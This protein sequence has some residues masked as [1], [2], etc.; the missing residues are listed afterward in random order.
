MTLASNEAGPKPRRADT[1]PSGAIRFSICTLVTDLD[2]YAEMV[3]SFSKGGFEGADCEFLYLDNSKSNA[4][5]A[6][7]GYNLFLTRA[8]GDYLILCH[9]DI[10]LLE[11]GRSALEKRLAELD[12][13]DPAWA[14]CG[15]AGGVAGGKLA[16][17]ISDPHGADQSTGDFPARAA[18]LDENFIVVR[19]DSN[20]AL[21]HD[22]GGFHLYGADLCIVADMLG[23]TAYVI[24][25]HLRHKS[26]GRT[27]AN[28]YA[29]RRAA[30][31]KYRRA[32]RSRWIRTTCTTFL[33]SGTPLLGR[34]LSTRLGRLFRR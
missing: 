14:L 2:E 23:R 17:R 18:A 19:R 22:L 6:F 7:A 10:L 24:D 8:S 4:F 30:I 15:N 32:L 1:L 34:I 28:F 20:L 5:D 3:E 16:I 33:V 9:Q 13:L 11:Q 12:E 31:A 26:G 21:S 29:A 27:D 25:F